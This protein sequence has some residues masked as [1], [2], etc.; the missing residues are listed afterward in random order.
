M[1]EENKVAVATEETKEVKERSKTDMFKEHIQKIVYQTLGVKVSKDKAWALFKNITHGT[2]E[3]VLNIEETVDEEGNKSGKKL[4]LAGVGTFCILE[5]KPRGSKAGLDK[6][7]NPI[8]GA[9]VWACVPR[10]RFYPSSVTEKLV[11]QAY[12][13]A[14]HGVEVEHY[15]IF[16]EDAEPVV[17]EKA[18][19]KQVKK[20]DKKA[21]K[22]EAKAAVTEPVADEE[23]DEFDDEI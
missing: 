1:A 21:E 11:E 10:Y 12:G 22:K 9:E 2:T 6:D 19:K 4:P 18:E 17:E 20:A 14:D 3:F 15:G 16:K 13:L 23:F 8:E 5:T 7:G